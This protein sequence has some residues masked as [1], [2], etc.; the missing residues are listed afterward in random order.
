MTG[1]TT[2]TAAQLA[3]ADVTAFGGVTSFD[4]ALIARYA[5]ALPPPNGNSGTWFFTPASNMYASIT[6][7]ITGED[8]AALLMGD[9][10]GNWGDPSPFRV[11]FGPERSTAVSAARMA[12]K[13]E[14]DILI[15]VSIQGAAD[16]GIIAY[17]FEL[18]YDPAVIQP[19]ENTVDLAGTVS[20][21]FAAV[22][23]ADQPGLLRVVVYGPIEIGSNGVLL[24]LRFT[25]VGYPGSVSP[26]TWESILFN[27]GD[28]R[29]TMTDGQIEISN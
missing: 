28:P 1:A 12:A 19:L 7:D 2:L 5:A 10:S 13:P 9:V 17:Q 14:G 23:N 24:N 25:A 16:K 29:A 8:F 6:S 11:G 27:E 20:R 4:A 26:L 21:G 18:R 3:V 22:V 15:P